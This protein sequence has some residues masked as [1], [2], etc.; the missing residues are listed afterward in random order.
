MKEGKAT[1][2]AALLSCVLFICIETIRDN[3][4]GAMGLF[5]QGTNMLKQIDRTKMTLDEESMLALM[6]HIF[7]RMAVQATLYGHPSAADLRQE[8]Q[9]S[10]RRDFDTLAEARSSLFGLAVYSHA[11][12][13]QAGKDITAYNILSQSRSL[14]EGR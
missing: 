10:G 13:R 6:E 9:S 7:Q 3:V 11:F 12:M 14:T 1:S 8:I 5:V 2:I 4:F